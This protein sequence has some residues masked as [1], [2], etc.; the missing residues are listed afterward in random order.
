MD[1]ATFGNGWVQ[2]SVIAFLAFAAVLDAPVSARGQAAVV[3]LIRRSLAAVAAVTAVT[4]AA[5]T[6]YVAATL[7]F[8]AVSCLDVVAALAA[9]LAPAVNGPPVVPGNPAVAARLNAAAARQFRA[10]KCPSVAALRQSHAPST[11]VAA[12]SIAPSVQRYISVPNVV[13]PAVSLDASVDIA[14]LIL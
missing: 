9:G 1:P 2:S 3:A 6:A 7:K 10:V 12:S 4:A 5:A 14:L 8:P 11:L 13:N